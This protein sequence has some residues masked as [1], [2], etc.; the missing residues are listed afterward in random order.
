[1]ALSLFS[2]IYNRR[3][4]AYSGHKR[5]CNLPRE[6]AR[7]VAA[8]WRCTGRQAWIRKMRTRPGLWNVYCGKE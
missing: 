6:T 4:R 5:E 1:M 3:W 8:I 7:D 2:R